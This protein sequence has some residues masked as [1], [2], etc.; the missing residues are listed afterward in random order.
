MSTYGI[1]ENQPAHVLQYV[2][3]RITYSDMASLALASYT[4][5]TAIKGYVNM[6]KFQNGAAAGSQLYDLGRLLATVNT[7]DEFGNV[8]HILKEVWSAER[9]VEKV[10]DIIKGFCSVSSESAKKRVSTLFDFVW[11]MVGSLED[12]VMEATGPVAD[13]EMDDMVEAVLAMNEKIQQRLELRKQLQ[14]L[15]LSDSMSGT[16]R[17]F[18]LELIKKV[19]TVTLFDTGLMLT[20][21]EIV[22]SPVEGDEGSEFI[23]MIFDME[24]DVEKDEDLLKIGRVARAFKELKKACSSEEEKLCATLFQ[25][26]LDEVFEQKTKAA[27]LAQEPS[28]ISWYIKDH[29]FLIV[30]GSRVAEVLVQM[31]VTMKNESKT[32]EFGNELSKLRRSTLSE[33]NGER[34]LT[35]FRRRLENLMKSTPV[36]SCFEQFF[37]FLE[38]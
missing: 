1:F 9:N 29:A 20:F 5:L 6:V 31:A 33:V 21:L 25:L 18:L 30:M 24:L 10:G 2:M 38:C 15:F 3:E 14:Q 32:G 27:L 23:E 34:H 12:S 8:Q 26:L 35:I 19:H 16:Y 37:G 4:W 28:L 36:Y 13:N 11:T 22:M 17:F 7:P